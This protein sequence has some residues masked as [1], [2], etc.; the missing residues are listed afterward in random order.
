MKDPNVVL[1]PPPLQLF[2]EY[3]SDPQDLVGGLKPAQDADHLWLWKSIF[4]TRGRYDSESKDFFD[5]KAIELAAVNKD[6]DRLT[7]QRVFVELLGAEVSSMGFRC[8][9]CLLL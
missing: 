1:E 7:K 8:F 4:Q 9:G 5:R 3:S 2:F 6:W